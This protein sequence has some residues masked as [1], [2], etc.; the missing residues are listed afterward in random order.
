MA[1]ATPD[2]VLLGNGPYWEVRNQVYGIASDSSDMGFIRQVDEGFEAFS[3][4]DMPQ[5]V[6]VFSSLEA[7]K[8][9]LLARY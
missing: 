2:V 7:A 4:G 5:S 6:G 8:L 1:E 3:R 9:A